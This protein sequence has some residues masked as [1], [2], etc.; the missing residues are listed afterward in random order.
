MTTTI[1]CY[2]FPPKKPPSAW[3]NFSFSSIKF[4][5]ISHTVFV[6]FFFQSTECRGCEHFFSCKWKWLNRKSRSESFGMKTSTFRNSWTATI[7][8]FLLLTPVPVPGSNFVCR[9]PEVPISTFWFYF[10]FAFWIIMTSQAQNET[11]QPKHADTET[12]RNGNETNKSS[13]VSTKINKTTRYLQKGMLQR[14]RIVFALREVA[15][16]TGETNWPTKGFLQE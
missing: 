13:K 9:K 1:T 4:I 12:T 10:S 6:S 16:A 8:R 7:L 3:R 11:L 5:S 14:A 15:H 2:L